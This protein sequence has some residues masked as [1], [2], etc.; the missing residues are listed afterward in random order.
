MVRKKFLLAE[1]VDKYYEAP[2]KERDRLAANLCEDIL[3][4]YKQ[5][6]EI[7]EILKAS[8]RSRRKSVKL[9]AEAQATRA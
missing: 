2:Q 5:P 9:Q 6:A 1:A 4:E 7:Y 3:E 8:R